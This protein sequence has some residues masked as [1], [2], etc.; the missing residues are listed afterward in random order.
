MAGTGGFMY[1]KNTRWRFAREEEW[2]VVPEA[3]WTPAECRDAR[4]SFSQRLATARPAAPVTRGGPADPASPVVG[5]SYAVA[6]VE[7]APVAAN[8]EALAAM[9]LE[10]GPEGELASHTLQAAD[11]GGGWQVAG[12]LVR[13]FKARAGIARQGL[14]FVYE[15]VG[16]RWSAAAAFAPAGGE[17]PFS[18]AGAGVSLGGCVLAVKEFSLSVNNNVFLGPADD[19][20]GAAFMAAGRSDVTGYLVIAGDRRDLVDGRG[21]AL[22]IVMPAGGEAV[23]IEADGLVVTWCREIRSAAAGALQVLYFEGDGDGGEGDGAVRVNLV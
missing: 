10:R 20:G 17:R 15:C 14:E 18:F 4:V 11:E 6:R 12:A 21:R 7:A 5:I 8:V 23:A 22:S 1:G 16:R 13:R 19:E 2:G 9:A 3:G